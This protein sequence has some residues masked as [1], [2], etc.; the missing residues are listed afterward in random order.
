M[1]QHVKKQLIDVIQSL[2]KS[3]DIIEGNI[4]L[5]DNSS[6]IELLTQCQQTAI[7]IGEIIEQSEGDGTNTVKLL[8]Q[9]CEDIYQL[10]LVELDINKSRK[11]I[12]RIRNY[13][14]RISNSIS[15]E[16]PDSKKEIVFL[17]YNAS[18]WDSLESVWKAT[19]EDN[20]C[21][22]YVIPIPY[23]DKN[24]D[25]TL[26]QMHYEGDK[27]PEYVPITSWED[28]NLAERQPDVAYIHN[29]YDYANKST[30]IH[31]D[32]YAKELKKHVGMLVYIPYFVSAGDVPKHFCVLPGTM[33][34]DKVIVL[35]EKEKQTYITEFR[36]FET[37]NN[38][39][40]LFGN[41]D[42]K[43][44]VL[45]SPKLDKVTSVSR[46]NINIPEE[47]ERV[48]KRPDGSRKKVILYNTT[49]QA[50]L[51]NDEKYINKLKKV[52]G[53][54]YEKQ[55]DITIL[56][57]PHPL[58]E[59]TIASMKP[60]LLSEY[61]DIMKNYKQQSYGIYDDTSDLY[62]AIALSDAYYGDYSSVAVLYKETGKPIM[63]QNVEV[64]I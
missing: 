42:D 36:K 8:E 34:A 20:S 1:R 26:G 49:L 30:S 56:W 6:L 24:P 55:E 43:F 63:I 33:Y 46:E 54:F 3:N 50:V 28:Y 58:M 27:F 64:R 7:E 32:F 47:W 2:M 12:K 52:L 61:N 14:P 15:Y 9:Y 23:F 10:S 5:E 57:R 53:F 37:E 35:S 13:I 18:M 51:D 59:T 62:R 38:C 45:G 40:G 44:I 48:I 39:K 19:E 41:L 31:L 11:I 25:G 29:P 60:H 16:I 22:A 4:G 21:N 17:P